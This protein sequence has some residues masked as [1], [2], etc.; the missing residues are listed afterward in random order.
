MRVLVTGV[1]GYLGSHAA[2]SLL[3][4]GCERVV[5]VDSMVRGHRG[6]LRALQGLAG[7]SGRFAAEVL[8]VRDRPRLTDLLRR[9]GVGMAW[10]FAGLTQVGESVAQ[11]DAYWG[12]NVEG[13]E[14]L[15][16]ALEAAEVPHLV[17]SSSA[18][19]YGTPRELPLAE[20][21]P[22]APVNP[23]GVTKL[24]AERRI[25]AWAEAGGRA[26]QGGRRAALLRYFNVAGAAP[27]GSLGE[28]HRPE[29]HLVPSAL[30]V[31]LGARRGLEVLG[32]DYPT[33]DGTCVRDYVHVDDLMEAHLV[34]M[35][36]LAR[37]GLPSGVHPTEGDAARTR[38][39]D[40]HSRAWNVGVGH[41]FSVL[42]VLDA[43]RRVTGHA[44]P[45][46]LAP[47]REGDPARLVADASRIH[48]ELGWQPRHTT[49]DSMVAS[50]WH[51]MRRHPN[52]YP[53]SP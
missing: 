28:D 35:R 18:A 15:L 6:A 2:R 19:V 9:E 8:D 50:A 33:P 39:A 11:P 37:P 22:L 46:T 10:H 1:A 51:W 12:A 13:T 29:T 49:L 25:Q 48:R 45:H 5:G 38:D 36:W 42:E 31:A 32:S 16:A 26:G 27:D 24:E 53:P 41:A 40:I 30:Q 7:G 20:T 44:I 3:L 47:R 14:S 23:Y 52:G 43:C 17:F 4:A 34:A 21:S